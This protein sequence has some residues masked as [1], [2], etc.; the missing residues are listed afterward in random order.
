MSKTVKKS[1]SPIRAMKRANKEP[2]GSAESLEQRGE[3]KGN[4]IS[5]S[6]HRTQCRERVSQAAER[7]RLAAGRKDGQM[8]ALLHHVSADALMV[9]YLNLKREASAGVDRITWREYGENLEENLKELHQRVHSN[10]YR[11]SPVLRVEIPKS[12]G[13]TRPLG[14]TALED[15]I[16]QKTVVDSILSHIYEEHFLGL[17]YGFRPGRGA[18]DALDALA[19]GIER[20]KVNWI[21]DAD[22]KSYFDSVDRKTLV[23]FLEHLIGDKRIIRLIQK[24]LKSGVMLKDT[25]TDT[26]RGTPQGSCIS[27]MLSNIY[28]HYVLDLWFQKWRKD[29]AKGDVIMVRYADDFVVGFQ[30]KSEAESFLKDLKFRFKKFSLELHPEKTRLVEFGQLAEV[31][32]RQRGQGRPET[33]KFLG[34]TH[35]CTTTRTKSFRLG[36]KPISKRVSRTFQRLKEILRKRVYKGDLWECGKWLGKVVNGW[37]NYYAVPGSMKSLNKFVLG[38]K[39]I[40]MVCIRRRSQRAYFTWERLQKMTEILWPRVTIRHP[41][42]D[43]RA[44]ERYNLR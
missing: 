3:T 4:S 25:L 12:D 1:D 22:I 36:R 41:W 8:T 35:F 44:A 28:L 32:R 33:F 43:R 7:V 23:L 27:P 31:N 10:A 29:K 42:P 26:G 19:Y 39:K 5:Q 38:V 13:G 15:K 40:W 24:W 21:L 20:K 14:V 18:H 16:V 37:L 2:S 11:A 9:A 17:S 34:F 6:I 30:H